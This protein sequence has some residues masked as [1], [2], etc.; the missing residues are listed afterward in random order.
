[1]CFSVE[2]IQVNG[3][4]KM[5]D[6]QRVS[7]TKPSG[8]S[9]E[10]TQG[11][12]DPA[13]GEIYPNQ[14]AQQSNY[15]Q[16]AVPQP[17]NNV[18]QQGGFAQQGYAQPQNVQPYPQQNVPYQQPN[19]GIPQPYQQDA[20]P[21]MY[22]QYQPVQQ[23]INGATKFCKHCGQI[24]PEDAVICTHCGRQVEELRSAAAAQPIIINNN[25]NNNIAVGVPTGR[26][27]NKWVALILCFFFGYLGV[28]RFYE[29]KIGTGILWL[30]T[31]GFFGI[32]DLIDFIILLCKPNPYYV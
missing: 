26:K 16:Q 12:R 28:H 29:G 31:L 27:K 2:N 13:T 21:Q 24:I 4:N 30:C 9:S 6:N 1:M 17:T 23:P 19:Q 15:A 18:W 3:G 25:N 7:L 11:W 14:P 5:D 22:Q 20:A 8:A 10:N 32:G